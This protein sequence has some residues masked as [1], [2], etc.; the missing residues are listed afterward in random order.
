MFLEK[1]SDIKYIES[2]KNIGGDKT[3]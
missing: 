3:E 2:Y 1:E